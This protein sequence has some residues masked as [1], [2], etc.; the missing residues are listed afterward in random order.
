MRLVPILLA[1]GLA[2]LGPAAARAETAPPAP[3]ATPSAPATPNPA[4]QATSAGAALAATTAKFDAFVG[5]M[6]RSLRSVDSLARYRSWVDMRRGP[7]GRERIVYGL[8]APYDLTDER[9]AAEAALAAPPS[10][11][12]LDDAVRAYVAASDA[13]SPVLVK[14]DGYYG[15]GDYKLDG[16]AG[17]RA[18]HA[19]IAALGGAFL[20]ARDRL[21]AVMRTEKLALD[22]IRLATIEAREGR[23]AR[24]HVA[25]VMMTGKMALDAL[26]SRDA[27]SGSRVDVP[28]FDAAMAGFGE[29]VKAM[30]DYAAA[31]RDAFGAFG[32]FP[33][34]L[35]SHLR[36]VQGRLKVG[37]GDL[38]RAAGANGGIDMTLIQSDWN[39][40][41]TTAQLPSLGGR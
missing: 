24:W 27:G 13:L 7:T 30:D 18:M 15:R 37:K 17:G 33:D 16:M 5:Y 4:A 10:L 36:E 28:A 41:V 9:A 40:M 34:G 6:N 31:H 8:Y 11:P 23:S 1:L 32:S 3:S 22:R 2:A 19:D 14:A 20:A 25:D 38:R 12:D 35:L 29:A 21:E 26:D 39:T